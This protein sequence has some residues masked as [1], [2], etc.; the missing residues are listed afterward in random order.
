MSIWSICICGGASRSTPG[1]CIASSSSSVRGHNGGRVGQGASK[2]RGYFFSKSSPGGMAW[3]AGI[4]AAGANQRPFN[5][6]PKF[7]HH[8][9]MVKATKNK[10]AYGP[11]TVV[12][13]LGTR[14]H[15]FD[16]ANSRFIHVCRDFVDHPRNNPPTSTLHSVI[17]RRNSSKITISRSQ[18]RVG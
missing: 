4:V 8:R 14:L 9:V 1:M 10:A 3:D 6:G 16:L 12:I 18:S 15:Y 2:A 17:H 7:H 5:G 13:K 11:Y